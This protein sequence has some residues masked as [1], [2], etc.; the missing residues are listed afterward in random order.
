M[1]YSDILTVLSDGKGENAVN[2]RLAY[3]KIS[4]DMRICHIKRG[5]IFKNLLLFSAKHDMIVAEPEERSC[6]YESD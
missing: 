3:A 4:F 6:R 2:I 1:A 5:M